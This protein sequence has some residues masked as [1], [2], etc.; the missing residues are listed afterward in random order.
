MCCWLGRTEHCREILK[1]SNEGHIRTERGE[2]RNPDLADPA[3]AHAPAE[4]GPFAGRPASCR[5]GAQIAGGWRGE[6]ARCPA[7]V[8]SMNRWSRS[9]WGS[10][11]IAGR[12]HSSA[13]WNKP[14]AAPARRRVPIPGL[15]R[16]SKR[17]SNATAWSSRALDQSRDLGNNLAEPRLQFRKKR[18]FIALLDGVARS[19]EPTPCAAHRHLASAWL[20]GCAPC[21]SAGACGLLVARRDDDYP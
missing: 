6:H 18:N 13:S 2:K 4:S 16:C 10:G 14:C 17:V 5:C 9:G 15:A 7:G 3:L 19:T 8:G 1:S 12:R 20:R 21:R 11:P